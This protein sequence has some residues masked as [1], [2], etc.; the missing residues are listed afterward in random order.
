[1]KLI[2]FHTHIYPDAVASK[3]TGSVEKFYD[4]EALCI[5]TEDELHRVN[6]LAGV[7]LSVILPVAVK[8]TGVI[9][10]ND[11][12]LGVQQRNS[13]FLSFGTIHAAM[14]GI[15]DEIKR[16]YEAGLHGIKIHPDTQYFDI[17]D[18]R[19]FP[20]YDYM[21]G[22]IPLIVHTG[23]P[24]YSYSHPSRLRRV[25]ENFPSLICIAAHFGG[26]SMVDEG[27]KNLADKENCY[28]DMSSSFRWTPWEKL[29]DAVFSYG[30]DRVLFASDFPLGSP[31]VEKENLLSMKLSDDVKEKIAYKNAEKLLGIKI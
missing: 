10:I 1:M 12:A 19:M 23:D 24:R 2:D 25:M 14:D 8:P 15:E 31:V 20:V 17:D 6:A 22:K 21:Q 26:W 30:E 18:E 4:S 28:V 29:N 27:I 5:G 3:A 13:D 7:K 9:H 11:Y 16:V